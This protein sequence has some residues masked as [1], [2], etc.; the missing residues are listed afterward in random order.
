MT[1]RAPTET[2]PLD[3]DRQLADLALSSGR[4][5]SAGN[6]SI[7]VRPTS[8]RQFARAAQFRS[9]ST[10]HCRNSPLHQLPSIK[11]STSGRSSG[12]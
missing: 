9:R 1:R 12:R 11:I 5:R 2:L 6:V 7:Y 3:R 8:R 10:V 4:I